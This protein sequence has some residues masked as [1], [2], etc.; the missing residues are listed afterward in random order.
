MTLKDGFLA[1]LL[2]GSA[3]GA[4]LAVKANKEIARIRAESNSMTVI[5]DSMY[6]VRL[7][8]WQQASD[9]LKK[10]TVK[11]E[12]HSKRAD[13]AQQSGA[14]LNNQ[15]ATVVN[16]ARTARDSAD[17]LEIALSLKDTLEVQVQSLRAARRSDSLQIEILTI[18]SLDWKFEA[19]SLRNTML[20]LNTN[21]RDIAKAAGRKVDLGILAVSEKVVW[22]VSGALGGLFVGSI[23]N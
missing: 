19:D 21:V 9:S 1:I 23:V 7:Q 2:V 17:A 11:S 15:L 4:V 8:E 3:V 6:K 22:G 13:Q 12:E 18:E 5:R 10:L 16:A 20:D 14:K